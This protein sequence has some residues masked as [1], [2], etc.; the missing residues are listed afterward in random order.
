MRVLDCFVRPK[1]AGQARAGQAY[2]GVYS[3]NTP[4]W[5]V[6]HAGG[7]SGQMLINASLCQIL[8]SILDEPCGIIDVKFTH[9]VFPVCFYRIDTEKKFL[10]Y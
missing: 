6:F 7:G 9:Q 4:K 2:F 5:V 8:Q 3:G 1:V 10:C